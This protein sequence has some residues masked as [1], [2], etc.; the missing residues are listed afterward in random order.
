V[1]R[2]L[3]VS[4]SGKF[5]TFSG[6]ES[7]IGNLTLGPS[8]GHN[9][10]FKYPNGSYKPILNIYFPRV[11]SNGINLFNLM[12]F[13][14]CNCFLKIWKSIR[15]PT[16]KVRTH[17]G[18]CGFNSSHSPTFSGAWNVIH[19]LHFWLAP[20]QAFALVAS[21]RLGLWHP[22]WVFHTNHPKKPN[23]KIILSTNVS[24]LSKH[25][26]RFVYTPNM[27]QFRPPQIFIIT[28]HQPFISN[29]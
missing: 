20:L 18:V 4:K 2:H 11:F 13:D 19:K 27:L 3:H 9:L 14:P 12:S 25:D 5:L 6:W 1:A 29:T 24:L 21:P 26:S 28:W 7:K 8:F 17:L 23:P 22:S 15:P 10:C 16:P